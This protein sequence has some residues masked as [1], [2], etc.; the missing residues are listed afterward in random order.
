MTKYICVGGNCNGEWKE[1]KGVLR[2][3]DHH[4]FIDKSKADINTPLESTVYLK[5][6]DYK[7]TLFTI[8]GEHIF[9]FRE[10]N[11]TELESFKR[12][13]SFYTLSAKV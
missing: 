11:L 13:L 1:I 4:R 3:N 2:H 9:Y 7:A 6:S 10:W 8:N 5:H 12:I